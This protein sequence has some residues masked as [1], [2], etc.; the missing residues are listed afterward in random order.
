MFGWFKAIE[1]E[2]FGQKLVED[3][4]RRFPPALESDER[5]GMPSSRLSQALVEFYARAEKFRV[6]ENLGV[7]KKAKLANTVKWRMKELGYSEVL[8]EDMI[9]S[10][11]VRLAGR[12]RKDTK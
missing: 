4:A 3:F 6:Q 1:V 9:K 10:L 11:A 8:I 2:A 5:P 12:V 7:Y